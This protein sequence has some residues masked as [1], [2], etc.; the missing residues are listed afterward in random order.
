MSK[1]NRDEGVILGIDP[2]YADMGYGVISVSGII[3][4]YRD[5]G[6]LQTKST[7]PMPERLKALRD[8]LAALC[9]SYRPKVMAIE[10]LFFFKNVTTAIEVAQA[11][12]VALLVAA[13]HGIP[14]MEFTPLEVK[15]GLTSY[16]KADKSQVAHM[17]KA[18]LG[19]NVKTTNDNALDALAI[20]LAASLRSHLSGRIATQ[21]KRI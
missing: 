8:G 17:V 16:G 10:K 14:V 9:T 19:P 12:G 18:L 2:G 21:K 11:R 1:K 6:S 15:Q 20:A 4:S 7:T 5:C 13:E 3:R